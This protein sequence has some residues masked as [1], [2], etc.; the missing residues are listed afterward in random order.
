VIPRLP[1]P[2]RA[3]VKRGLAFAA[4]ERPSM[5][6][7]VDGLRDAVIPPRKNVLVAGLL[8]MTVAGLG[9]L[10]TGR[11]RRGI[12]IAALHGALLLSQWGLNALGAFEEPQSSWLP[13]SLL[14][15]VDL[16]YS[17]REVRDQ[18][19][20]ANRILD[21]EGMPLRRFPLAMLLALLLPLIMFLGGL[22]A[23]LMLLR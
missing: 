16:F 8:A 15:I 1:R 11:F 14:S 19:R 12:I 18:N 10:Y 20:A 2:L 7:M 6:Q 3:L 5:Q 13:G 23:Y 4:A 22:V 17:L 9:S 21:R